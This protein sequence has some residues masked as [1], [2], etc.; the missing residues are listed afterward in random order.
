MKNKVVGK[1]ARVP[2]PAIVNAQVVARPES[3]FD[4]VVA[5]IQSAREAAL[6]TVNSELVGLYWQI[7]EYIHH[8]LASAEWGDGV[9]DELARHLA[10]TQP[11]LRGFTRPNL[12][13]MKQFY[14]TYSGDTKVSP[15][16][17]QMH[18][19]AADIFKD[20]YVV[21]FLQLPGSHMETDLHR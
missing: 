6:R 21:E 1:T 5:L 12:F 17:R 11:G 18:P 15:L 10:Q 7:G 14:E 4:E 13:R 3:A 19:D 16:V 9:V 8:K 20:S 2:K